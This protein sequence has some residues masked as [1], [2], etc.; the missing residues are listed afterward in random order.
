MLYVNKED[1][2]KVEINWDELFQTIEET[3]RLMGIKG[4]TSQPEHPFIDFKDPANRIIALPAYV[5][6]NINTA[7][8]KWIAS[9]PDNINHNMPRA[10]SV[11]ILNSAETGVPFA[12]FNS[13]LLSIVRTSTVTGVVLNKYLKQQNKKVKIGIVGFGPIG[14]MQ[15]RM[16]CE[17]F[18]DYIDEIK[19]YDLRKINFEFNKDVKSSFVNSWQETYE[20]ADVFLNTTVTKERYV[21]LKPKENAILLNVSLRDYKIDIF[22]W[23]KDGIIVDDWFQVCR[24]N[25]DIERFHI[26]KNLQQEDVYTMLD[27]IEEK[28]FGKINA[29]N[30]MFNPFGMSTFD[31]AVGNYYYK[32]V[33]EKHLGCELED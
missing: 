23:I 5:G 29:K 7:G 13:T 21:D 19:I 9:F 18:K 12:I 25:T 27:V 33:M 16:M 17:K 30:Y 4:E 26:E 6:G 8:I 11:T 14:Q 28:V 20:D 24:K 3:T 32:K 1:A 15:Y 2:E 22:D 10:N 31:I